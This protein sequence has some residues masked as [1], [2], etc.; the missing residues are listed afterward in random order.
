MANPSWFSTPYYLVSK[1]AQLASQGQQMTIPQIEAAIAAAGYTPYTHYLAYSTSELTDPNEYFSTKEVLE[2]QA[3]ASGLP[4]TDYTVIQTAFVNAGFTNAYDWWAQYGWT[5][6]INPSNDFNVEAYLEAKA[7]SSVPPITVAAVEAAFVAAGLTPLSH[8]E[9]YGREE[10]LQVVPVYLDDQVAVPA[11]QTIALTKTSGQAVTGGALS[12]LFTAVAS[13]LSRENTLHTSDTIDGGAGI[14]TLR[15][16]MSTDFAGFAAG[17][18]LTNI[19]N[20]QLINTGILREYNATGSDGVA[21]YA[22]AGEVDLAELSSVANIVAQDRAE[23]L[24]I[25]FAADVTD[26]TQTLNLTTI[27]V[28][29][30]DGD[31]VVSEVKV[32]ATGVGALQLDVHGASFLD[33]SGVTDATE[34]TLLGDGEAVITKVSAIKTVDAAYMSGDLDLDLDGANGVTRVD[35]GTG[36]TVIHADVTVAANDLAKNATLVGNGAYDELYLT[37]TDDTT[38]QYTSTGFEVIGFEGVTDGKT[39]TF[40][41]KNSTGIEEVEVIGAAV[42]GTVTVANLGAIDLVVSLEDNFVAGGKNATLNVDNT[43]TA[44]VVANAT[45]D[46]NAE[47]IEESDTAVVLTKATGL[48]VV[49]E[50]FTKFSGSIT[51]SKATSAAIAAAGQLSNATITAGAATSVVL[52][53]LDADVAQTLTLAARSATALEVAS[54]GDVTLNVASDLSKVESLNVAAEGLFK[55]TSALSAANEIGLTGAGDIELGNAGTETYDL[56][57]DA[58]NGG[59]FDAVDLTGA[60][61]TV[62]VANVGGDV[63]V[64]DVFSAGAVKIDASTSL[65]DVAF[66]DIFGSTVTIDATDAGSFDARAIEAGSK[67]TYVGTELAANSVN[68]VAAVGSETLTVDV[69]GGIV[70][71]DVTVTSA[72]AT[73]TKVTVTGDLDIEGIGTDSVAVNVS[74]VNNIA[75]SVAVDISG[76]EGLE[77]SEIT[78][79]LNDKTVVTL[80]SAGSEDAIVFGAVKASTVSSFVVADGDSLNISIGTL[81]DFVT[82]AAV[83]I[84]AAADGDIITVDATDT[85]DL[86]AA[87]ENIVYLTDATFADTAGVLAAISDGDAGEITFKAAV[88]DDDI[89]LLWTD[90]TGKIHLSQLHAQLT[91]D[92]TLDGTST[93]IDIAIVGSTAALVDANVAFVA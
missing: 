56:I 9:S 75:N 31:G 47:N 46:A 57:I 60:R 83:A 32:N 88:D 4:Q 13:P 33:L 15:V 42:E 55:S 53:S 89:A 12:E 68:V 8:Y 5:N 21:N 48:D 72:R 52:T 84:N 35:T 59:T 14:N 28:G 37:A 69:I 91:V 81:A 41:A 74:A 70:A 34:L 79:S 93:L 51:A 58:A 64:N 18:G 80:G 11:N 82:L 6:N 61:V 85:S 39:L 26:G 7:M 27:D 90:T 63:A 50:E 87:T 92:D 45:V 71:D 1:Q 73:T 17:K 43:G 38:V 76:V 20:I 78:T 30:I 40:S 54:A 36:A 3:V 67:V 66:R 23:D 16:N 24:N 25:G 86:S 29:S 49:V 44:F 65:G 62:D 2:A 77:V 19:D 10:G 22:L